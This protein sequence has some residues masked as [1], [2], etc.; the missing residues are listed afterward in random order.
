M[1]SYQLAQEKTPKFNPVLSRGYVLS[2]Q[3]LMDW[4]VDQVWK[5][6]AESFPPEM[7]YLRQSRCTP[8]EMYRETTAKRNG[9][10]R[11][12]FSRTDIYMNRYEFSYK[13]ELMK[14]KYICL[15]YFQDGGLMRVMDAVYSIA[16]VLADQTISVTGKEIFVPLIRDKL[17]FYRNQVHSYMD[18][19]QRTIGYVIWAELHRDKGL[20]R[21]RATKTVVMDTAIMHYILAK[22]GLAETIRFLGLPEIQFGMDDETRIA[23]SHQGYRIFQTDG[24]RPKGYRGESPPTKLWFA[25]K[26]ELVDVAVSAFMANIFYIVDHFPE[27]IDM[28]YINTPERWTILLA[29]SIF[30]SREKE[31]VL[32][33]LIR[34]HLN[35]IEKYIDAVTKNW[36][37]QDGLVIN[38]FYDLLAEI[39]KSISVRSITATDNSTSLYGKR[40]M[41]QRYVLSDITEMIFKTLYPIQTKVK[42]KGAECKID[43]IEQVFRMTL[44]TRAIV[45]LNRSDHPEA[46]SVSNPTGCMAYGITS[47]VV[48]Q[49]PTGPKSPDVFDPFTMGLDVSILEFMNYLGGSKSEPTGR[50]H[51]NFYPLVGPGGDLLRNEKFRAMLDE[52]QE[53][54]KR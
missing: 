29:H 38:T 17:K 12:E 2:Q 36:F 8:E 48:L 52:V 11:Y 50:K 53:T 31:T 46:E 5:A 39:F 15:P 49:T 40:L 19:G 4:Y 27:R 10:M 28:E 43:D 32:L 18:N 14:P 54:F 9:G 26:N 42:N 13:G 24:I 34:T 30:A 21:N 20:K 41:V 44:K 47:R 3:H 16:P 45:R 25:V 33:E 23:L 22:Y 1:N 35:S 51:L 37:M 7:K 6:A